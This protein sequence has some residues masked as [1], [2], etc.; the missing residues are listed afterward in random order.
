LSLEA[1]I[2][3][4]QEFYSLDQPRV[5]D[6]VRRMG[7]LAAPKLRTIVREAVEL[8]SKLKGVSYTDPTTQ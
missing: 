7:L 6:R 2:K 3:K 4:Q 1:Q 5:R 8:A